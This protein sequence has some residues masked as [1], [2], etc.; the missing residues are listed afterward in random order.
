MIIIKGKEIESVHVEVEDNRFVLALLRQK[1]EVEEELD[2]I[3]DEFW[4]EKRSF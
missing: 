4:V 1:K 3:L 2:T